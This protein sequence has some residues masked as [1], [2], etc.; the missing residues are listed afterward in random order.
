MSHSLSDPAGSSPA[1]NDKGSLADTLVERDQAWYEVPDEMYRYYYNTMWNRAYLAL[2]SANEAD[3]IVDGI[4]DEVSKY[5]KPPS[6][7]MIEKVL[8]Q[9]TTW[10]IRDRL[11]SPKYKLL[12]MRS[13]PLMRRGHDGEEFE[14]DLESGGHPGADE[15]FFHWE[16]NEETAR[17]IAKAVIR[18]NERQRTCFVL[19]FMEK[20]EPEEIKKLLNIPA[21]TVSTECYR[22]RNKIRKWLRE[23]EQQ[24]KEKT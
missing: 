21:E 10:R 14:I 4:I 23:W 24:L 5:E 9:L 13:T 22:A 12:R 15:E 11:K 7:D 16:E 20:M 2:G 18:L 3:D 8:H 19:R 6:K 1:P 17:Q